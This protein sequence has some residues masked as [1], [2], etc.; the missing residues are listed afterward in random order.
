VE[1]PSLI[2]DRFEV[3]RELGRGASGALFL[4]HDRKSGGDPCA[5]KVLRPRATDPELEPLFRSE[6]V[7]LSGLAHESI[8]SVRDFGV[9]PTGEPFFT[10][11]YVP[12]EN[13]RVFVQE[14]R[15]DAA[16]YLG[17]ASGLLGA[18][19]HIHARGIL[20]RDVKPEN[21]ILRLVGGRRVPVLVDFG[22]AMSS[23]AARP[24]EASGTIPYIAPEVLQG[25]APDARSDLFSLGILLF[26]VCTGRPPAPLDE[27]LRS[28]STVLAPDRVRRAM[29]AASRGAVPRRFEEFVARLVAPTPAAR[30]PSAG[31][32]LHALAE[33]YEDLV[34]SGTFEPPSVPM[35][36]ELPLVG[37]KA[38][39]EALLGRVLALQEGELLDPIVIVAGAAGAGVTR[40]LAAVRNHAAAR[41]ALVFFA[42]DFRRLAREI[43]EH[44]SFG[45][46]VQE[47]AEDPLAVVYQIVAR[48]EAAPHAVRPVLLLDDVHRLPAADC[49]AIRDWIAALERDTGRPRLLLALGGRAEEDSPGAALL[50]TAGRSVPVELRSL[51]PLALADVRGALSVML[52]TARPPA[53]VVQALHRASDGNPRL[54]AQLVR[55]LADEKVIA[56]AAGRMQI[57]EE[58][59]RGIRLP[60]DVKAAARRRAERLERNLADRLAR[61][62]LVE[63]PLPF[64]AARALGR[65]HLGRLFA[66]GLLER[67]AGRVRFPDELARAGADVLVGERR[68]A[69]LVETAGL[70]E[71]AAP[72][73]A[74]H[75]WAQAG[76]LQDARRVGLP[77]IAKLEAAHRFDDALRLAR[78]I[79]GE[80]P[81]PESARALVALLRRFGLVDEAARTGLRHLGARRGPVDVD[82]L[83]LTA[84]SLRE[85]AQ[86]EQALQLLSRFDGRIPREESWR[87][88]N[89]KAAVLDRLDRHREALL[90][91]SRAEAAAGSIL[92]PGGRVARVRANILRRMKRRAAAIGVETAIV[93]SAPDAIDPVNRIAAYANRSILVGRSNRHILSVRDMRAGLRLARVGGWLRSAANLEHNLAE[94]ML[95]LGRNERALRLYERARRAF[96]RMADGELVAACLVG[97]ANALAELARPGEAESRLHRA[98]AVP[99][100]ERSP[101]I[102]TGGDFVRARLAI[103][104]G[105]AG[106]AKEAIAR[107]GEEEA[108]RLRAAL[109]LAQAAS[110][111][112]DV[113][114]AE[115]AWRDLARRNREL[116]DLRFFAEARVGLAECAAFR[117]AFNLAER[118]L[119]R[120]RCEELRWRTPVRARAELVRA[121]AALHKNDPARAGRH[122]EA[123]VAIANRADSMPVRALVYQGAA[124]LLQE[125]ELRRF[126]RQPT[127]AAAVL[128]LEGARAVWASYGNE[129]MLRKIDLHLAEL[130]RSAP[131]GMSSAETDRLVKI[132]H[133]VREMN[134]EFDRDRLLALI[135]DRAIELTGAE[136]GFVILLEEGKES[137]HLAR[138]LDR[139]AVSD[140]EQK[141]SSQI[142]KDVIRT[143]RAVVTENAESDAR[144]AEF[145]SVKN[146]RLRSVIAVPFRSKGR[147]LGALYL[148]NR[149]HQ[150][151]FTQHEERILELF[152]DQAVAA[153]EKAEL[154]QELERQ[155]EEIAE[156]NRQLKERLK[157]QDQ[158]LR[159]ARRELRAHRKE[160]G[161]GFDRIAA[162]SVAMQSVLREA[163]RFAV[164]DIPVL[165]IGENGTGKEMLA[166]AIHYASSRQA[167]AFVAVNCAAFPEGLLEAELFGHVR[168]SFTGA[169]RDRPGLFEEADGGTLFLDEIGDMSLAMQV[170][171]LRA[172]ESGEVK[173][174]G[175][176]KTRTVDVRIVAATNADLEELIAKARF[177][178]DLYYR[179]SGFVLRVPPLRERLEDIEP[180]AYAFVEEAA[181][182]EGR[183]GLTIGSDAIA[184][185][186]SYDWPGNVR[187]LR[188]VILRAVVTTAGTVIAPDDIAFDARATPALPGLD[189]SKVDK[190]LEELSNRG[191]DLNR[192]QQ[193]AV[194]RVL[195]RGKL[196]F[197]DYQTLFRIS[198]STTMRDLEALA[199][200]DLLE[201]RGKTRAALYLPGPKLRD[202]AKRVGTH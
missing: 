144:F 95:D 105:R 65:E 137:V 109:L 193:T 90:E 69:A 133:I 81:H 35:G 4:V 123:A 31:E 118:I 152:A 29:R 3:V 158:E 34:V 195:T 142:V 126:L 52:D 139:E 56:F 147:T 19:A 74:A 179:L 91:S 41:G 175:E 141:I 82:L 155:R 192:R 44:P 58:R 113:E 60:G 25:A 194:S 84:S 161:W 200:L 103:L 181:R 127:D 73:A 162:R 170:K 53:S 102:R 32:A 182:R 134:R 48:L 59:L 151:N 132:L 119:E 94:E 76:R 63:G 93:D 79:Q 68:S 196:T 173:R 62:A 131:S 42:N 51:P 55:L 124:S 135:L 11:D 6:F 129:A 107:S 159:L 16:G 202:L 50:R 174:V 45:A 49:S 10:M 122:L 164:S 47:P 46:P 176:N 201:K 15:L 8:V 26:E 138:N 88:Y 9:L 37:R 190:V 150:G 67:D 80:P 183:T 111:G 21:V 108:S 83:F 104:A 97:E 28:P 169:E 120:G 33:Q 89:A 143:G 156:L 154:V 168:G 187:E 78:A 157:S 1:A 66:L 12:G 40:L 167:R 185:L 197:G 153:I 23:S 116:R 27:L 117:G 54:L 70:L 189:P 145:F 130:P 96:A 18:L 178:Q 172:L 22:L 184:R 71:A 87:L 165:L 140:P 136:R 166:R 99:G 43:L 72:D 177:R 121:Q 146:L 186:E 5:L 115:S 163:K 2:L 39:L 75:L 110:L 125:I 7:L 148:D 114:A 20:H 106:E 160:R 188:N 112:E 24:G 98:A 77:A 13:C 149:F 64:E 100:A 198:K 180:L 191:I 14:D 128:L 30:L 171:L 101:G 61:F 36:L 86:P 85:A 199:D 57:D 92:G 17:L 38:A